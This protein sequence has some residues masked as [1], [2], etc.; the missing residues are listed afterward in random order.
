MEEAKVLPRA[1]RYFRSNVKR[2]V[3]LIQHTL[4][5]NHFPEVTMFRSIII[6]ILILAVGCSEYNLVEQVPDLEGATGVEETEVVVT[7]VETTSATDDTASE[8]ETEEPVDD[9]LPNTEFVI[10]DNEGNTFAVPRYLEFTINENSRSG[11]IGDGY[12]ETI[13]I[14]ATAHC[15]EIALEKVLLMTTTDGDDIPWLAHVP[16]V[17]SG[18]SYEWDGM[19]VFHGYG[20]AHAEDPESSVTAIYW[21]HEFVVPII[22]PRDETFSFTL[23]L[24]FGGDVTPTD[25]FSFRLYPRHTWY[26][27]DDPSAYPDPISSNDVDGNELFYEPS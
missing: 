19:H 3:F 4:V 11:A 25:G 27:T 1:S 12:Q 18:V 16:E 8:T 23:G 9:C 14:N 5:P 17:M 2:G 24:E 15:G 7:E 26:G 10:Q 20:E 6:S 13:T 22:I 21:D